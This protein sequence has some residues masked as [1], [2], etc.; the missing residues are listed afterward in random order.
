[1][2]NLIT[3]LINRLKAKKEHENRLNGKG[4][5]LNFNETLNIIKEHNKKVLLHE[6]MEVTN[7]HEWDIPTISE[8]SAL[9]E[10]RKKEGLV[11]ELYTKNLEQ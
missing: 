10:Q 6:L 5:I 2:L 11:T 3:K 1:M 4:W 9:I 7:T 8:L